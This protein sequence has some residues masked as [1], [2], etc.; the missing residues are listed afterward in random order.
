MSAPRYDYAT[1][2]NLL[3]RYLVR[4][5]LGMPANSVRPSEQE[6]PTGG[7]GQQFATVKIITDEVGNEN[8]ERVNAPADPLHPDV[9]QGILETVNAIHTFVASVNVYRHGVVDTEGRPVYGGDAFAKAAR[10]GQMLCSSN[11]AEILAGLGL[12][13]V[14]CGTARN[15][16][17]TVDGTYENRGQVDITF[18]IEN[19]EQVQVAAILHAD[20]FIK[21]QAPS[22]RITTLEVSA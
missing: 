2:C 11:S 22:G 13:Y 15:L 18:C 10:L 14:D 17:A 16:S 4:T 3:V 5:V 6:A 7:A 19:P 21:H 9:D 8:Y 12:G 1:A 20:V